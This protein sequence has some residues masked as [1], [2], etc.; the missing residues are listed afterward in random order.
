M[1]VLGIV[2]ARKGSKGIKGKNTKLLN[3]VRLIE[4]TLKAASKSNEL[5]SLI[6]SSDCSETLDIGQSYDCIETR[7]R[8][9][10][11]SNDKALTVDVIKHELIELKKKGNNYDIFILLQPTTPFRDYRDIDNCIKMLKAKKKGSIISVVDVGGH[12]PLRMKVIRNQLLY[13]YIET[14]VED[15]RPRQDLPK[16]FIRNG[17]IYGGY[18]NDIIDGKGIGVAPSI[19]YEMSPEKSVNIDTI[20]DY[21]MAEIISKSIQEAE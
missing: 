20:N 1:R 21:L 18:T 4:Y 19:A 10:H 14:G 3:G 5:D 7:I 16:V 12:H 8:P 17:S 9:E 6:V 11:L 13:N 2:P 15:M